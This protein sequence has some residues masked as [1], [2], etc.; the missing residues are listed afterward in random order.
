MSHKQQNMVNILLSVIIVLLMIIAVGA[1]YVWKNTGNQNNTG[2]G[3]QPNVNTW[4]ISVKIIS[5]TRCTN[6]FT[7]ELETNLKKIPALANVEFEAADFADSGISDYLLENEIKTL[8]AVIFN[9]SYI[10]QGI[11]S[12]LLPMKSGEYSLNIGAE[13]DPFAQRSERGFLKT[14][15]E[16]IA[17]IKEGS[18]VK[19][20][21]EAN[22]TWLEY[23]DLECPFCAKLHNSPT[24]KEVM[25]KYEWTVN[26]I[27]HHFPLN[28]HA[29]AQKAAETLECAA[30]L[31][32]SE[33]YYSLI[34]KSFEKYNNNNFTLS[35]LN[36]LAAEMGVNKSQLAECVDS[37]KYKEKVINQMQIGQANFNVTGTPGNVLINN[38]TG[39]YV[40]LSG[41]QG[42][43]AFVAAIESLK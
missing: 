8:P 23:S 37:G 29:N 19:G 17:K 4:E 31:N 42:T 18:Y 34:S 1:F 12:Y 6:C 5:D 40:V 28:F 35:G 16:N 39:E 38:T 24:P 25:E 7:N 33:V 32:G 10:D 15:I 30:Q 22:I 13:F 26:K 43:Q 27:F 3:T 9:R 36:D 41:A 14:E 11:N 2:T 20:D 21:A